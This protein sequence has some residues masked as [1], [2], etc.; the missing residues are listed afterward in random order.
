MPRA[1]RGGVGHCWR[2]PWS[3]RRWPGSNR[4]PRPGRP[5][6]RINF[7]NSLVPQPRGARVVNGA[8]PVADTEPVAFQVAFRM[9]HGAYP[10]TPDYLAVVEWLKIQGFTTTD[11]DPARRM[12]IDAK[13]TV[14]QA[15][16]ALNVSFE[17]V[18]AGGGQFIV[19]SSV[20]S[21]PVSVG[22]AVLGINGLQP[23]LHFRQGAARRPD[24][25]PFRWPLAA[26]LVSIRHNHFRY[27]SH[28]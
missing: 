9:E 8:Y 22:R 15:R 17:R 16:A 23:F 27:P 6:P 7:P 14:A 2:L 19:A 10:S 5:E 28:P 4:R 26:A 20:P 12:S 11:V 21:M 25:Q 24:H 18:E 13:G 3:C 1:C